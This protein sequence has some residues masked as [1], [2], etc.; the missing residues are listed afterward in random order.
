[1]KNTNIAGKILL[2]A[3][4]FFLLFAV[5]AKLFFE[6]Q[7]DRALG[8]L[9]FFKKNQALTLKLG[10]TEP[11][12]KLHP[13]ANDTGS[14]VRLLHLYEGLVRVTPDLRIEPALAL[15]YGLLNDT[16]WEFRL[17]P[18]VK[19]HNGKEITLHDVIFSLEQAMESTILSI[20]AVD[21]RTLHIV[22]KKPDPVFLS[23]L[24]AL[25]IFSQDLGE[26]GI[27]AGTGPYRLIAQEDGNLVLGKFSDYWGEKPNF[28]TVLLRS[29]ATKQ[30]KVAA[31]QNKEVDIL[32]NLP[33]D[34]GSNFEFPAYSLMHVPSLE[35]N[36]LL[37]NFEKTFQSRALREAV[38][39][40]IDAKSLSRFA[41]GFSTPVTQFVAKGIFGFDPTIQAIL[42][43]AEKARRLISETTP[44]RAFTLDLPPGLQAF[45]SAIS[46]SLKKVG[47][48]LTPRIRTAQELEKLILT[49]E[50]EFFFF[51]WKSDIGDS[52]DF[53]TAVVHSP[54]GVYGQFNGGNYENEAVDALI[55]ESQFN[56]KW[57]S[58]LKNLRDV[59]KIITEDDIFGI[60]LF[61]PDVL[62]AVSPRVRFIPR[63]DGLLLA[64]EVKIW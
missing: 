17:R 26:N 14:R 2:F 63:V 7:F 31:L 49:R 29:I 15:S 23:R 16:T 6:P 37:F 55:E 24:A 30:D 41:Q 64:Q 10:F 53:L 28:D 58:R 25:L 32:A 47:I 51:G 33:A 56:M 35:V 57:E 52:G 46:E 19:F 27:P 48:T 3:V 11:L 43:N 9:S 4:Y 34:M 59:M 21:E 61:S 20:Q 38:R 45:G 36:F 39:A 22:T 40:A 1:M 60:P 8:T 54:N 12:L 18:D 50:S 42:P 44:G 13:L 5:S 62:Y